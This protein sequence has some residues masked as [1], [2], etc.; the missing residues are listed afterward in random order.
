MNGMSVK[1]MYIHISYL[2]IQITTK[3]ILNNKCHLSHFLYIK[4]R[5]KALKTLG[6]SYQGDGWYSNFGKQCSRSIF[7]SCYSN[8]SGLKFVSLR[9]S[10]PILVP[11]KF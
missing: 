10:V 5:N 3:K 7:V 4:R 2:E 1:S 6:T 8:Q 9:Q 11:L